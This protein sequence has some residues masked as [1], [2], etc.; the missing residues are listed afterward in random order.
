MDFVIEPMTTEDWEQVRDIYEEGIRS[1]NATF[2]TSAP[3][4]EK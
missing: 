2:E 3:D 4:W 1:G